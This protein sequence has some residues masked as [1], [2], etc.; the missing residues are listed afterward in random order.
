[1]PD[2][3]DINHI[4][5]EDWAGDKLATYFDT[6]GQQVIFTIEDSGLGLKA[7]DSIELPLSD[8]IELATWILSKA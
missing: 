7:A 2:V 6:E 8:A 4:K 5:F 1:M 3:N